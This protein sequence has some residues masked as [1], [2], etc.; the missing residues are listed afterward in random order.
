MGELEL[1]HSHLHQPVHHYGTHIPLPL[2][3]K[4]TEQADR[5]HRGHSHGRR[6]L[7]ESRNGAAGPAAPVSTLTVTRSSVL[8]HYMLQ[9]PRAAGQPQG[10][11]CSLHSSGRAATRQN[12]TKHPLTLRKGQGFELTR[13][14]VLQDEAWTGVE[15]LGEEQGAKPQRLGKISTEGCRTDILGDTVSLLSS[16]PNSLQPWK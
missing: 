11:A 12:K 16:A 9:T 3:G 10:S 5:R 4:R 8:L 15:C 1:S 14:S 13:V 2:C 7:S 6:A